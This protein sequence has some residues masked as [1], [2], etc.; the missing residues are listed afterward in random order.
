MSLWQLGSSFPSSSL[1]SLPTESTIAVQDGA[2]EGR[3]VG[4]SV[5]SET[6]GVAVGKCDR[7][8]D[9]LCVG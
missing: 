1:Q 9:S 5:G 8:C 2:T 4:A 6:V 7:D 3:P